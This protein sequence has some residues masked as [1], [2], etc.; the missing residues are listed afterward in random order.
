MYR[1]SRQLHRW[2]GILA[3]LFLLVLAGS[4]FL[5]ANKDRWGW[6]RPPVVKAEEVTLAAEIVSIER[7]VEAAIALGHPNLKSLD[8]VDRVDYRPGKNIFK[9]ISNDG[10]REVQV[11]GKTGEVLSHS[12]RTDQLTEDIHDLSFFGK[13][14]HAWLLPVAALALFALAASGIGL[15]FT[16]IVRRWQFKRNPPAKKERPTAH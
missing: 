5:L 3:S 15:F 14:T 9:V 6:M 12:F 4:G 10:Y 2:V 7:A 1:S 8:D 11:D 16:P 13:L